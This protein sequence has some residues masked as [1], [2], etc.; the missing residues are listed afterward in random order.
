MAIHVDS[1]PD[2]IQRVRG[3]RALSLIWDIFITFFFLRL[4]DLFRRDSRKILRMKVSVQLQ[5]NII[6]QAKQ[7]RC[8]SGQMN[9]RN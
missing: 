3:L 8:T 4:R 9:L 6:S 5:G 7:E 1:K 2:M